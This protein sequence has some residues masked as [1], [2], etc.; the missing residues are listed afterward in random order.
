MNRPRFTTG[1]TVHKEIFSFTRPDQGPFKGQ[2]WDKL[3]MPVIM[4]WGRFL[5]IHEAQT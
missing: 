2:E 4:K 1:G 5:E 3:V